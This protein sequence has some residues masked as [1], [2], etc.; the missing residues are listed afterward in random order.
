MSADS[1]VRPTLW[2]A[3]TAPDRALTAIDATPNPTKDIH[4]HADTEEES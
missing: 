4:A 2:D 3:A 1:V